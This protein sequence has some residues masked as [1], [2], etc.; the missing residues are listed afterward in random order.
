[1]MLAVGF[2]CM[3]FI[4]LSY[5]SSK[6]VKRFYHEGMLNFVKYIL[7]LYRDVIFIS[8]SV[9]VVYNVD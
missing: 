4:I 6:F 7:Y 8:C 5:F 1:M 3:V 9:N 2:L